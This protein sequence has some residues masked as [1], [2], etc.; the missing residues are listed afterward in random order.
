ME[1]SKRIKIVSGTAAVAVALG[2][3]AALAA[4]DGAT[5]DIDLDDS[6]K[7]VAPVQT[8]AVDSG[9]DTDVDDNNVDDSVA[10]PFGIAPEESVASADVTGPDDSPV[11]VESVE[12][13]DSADSV[14]SAES[15]ESVDSVD[16]STDE[17]IDNDV[18]ED[19][20]E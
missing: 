9:P 11:S 2:A 14:E 15:A 10:T 19:V 12:S 20:D 7:I 8:S 6:T 18:D 13:S 16:E 5:G 1:F 3:G 4:D 17:S